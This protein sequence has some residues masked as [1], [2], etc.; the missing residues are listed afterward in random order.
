MTLM[1]LLPCLVVHTNES[2]LNTLNGENKLF[3]ITLDGLR[4]QE[5]F[6]G[7]D[8]ALLNDPAYNARITATKR[9]F[10]HP[11]EEE[12]RKKLLP[13]F[14]NVMARQGSLYGHRD[15]GSRMN[16]ANPYALSYPGYNELL[17]GRVDLSIY[18]NGR[19]A[20]P[21]RTVLDFLD[22][23][24]QFR[25][26]VAAFASW[27]AFPFILNKAKSSVYSNSG[28]ESI[29]DSDLSTTETLLNAV[30]AGMS[31]KKPARSDELTFLACREYV[32]KKKPSVVFL[33]FGGTDEAAHDKQYDLYLQQAA[34]ADRMLGELWQW[35]QTL[36][37]YA[38]KTTFLVTTDHGRGSNH[39][40]WHTHGVFVGGSSQTWMGLL[41]DGV[42]QRGEQKTAR[43]VYL[44]DL[45][46]LMLRILSQP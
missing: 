44:R 22:A 19:T 21:N 11:S 33:S 41:G 16:V 38:G 29:K 4:W 17:T 18:S 27:D 6:H 24:P 37:D 28:F 32:Q 8:S 2:P 5:V 31:D 46:S 1:S 34:G 45:K 35:L 3:I 7:A 14:W 43:Q 39:S 36:P 30:Q 15:K 25:G 23:T 9:L 40:T 20:N 42:A 26:K 12:R 13:F 10:W